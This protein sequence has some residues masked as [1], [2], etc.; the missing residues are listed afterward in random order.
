MASFQVAP[1]GGYI[2]LGNQ[3]QVVYNENYMKQAG[4]YMVVQGQMSMNQ[5]TAN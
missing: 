1:Q 2:D 3:K 5:T 4:N